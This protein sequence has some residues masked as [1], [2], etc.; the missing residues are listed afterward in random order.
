[1]D[2]N[3]D[4][5]SLR[6]QVSVDLD[7]DISAKL[8]ASFAPLV[9]FPA[10]QA[11]AVLTPGPD[12]LNF[13]GVNLQWNEQSIAGAGCYW[14]G[15]SPGLHLALSSRDLDLDA[16]SVLFPSGEADEFDLPLDV[17]LELRAE[18]AN[19]LGARARDVEVNVGI[20]RVCPDDIASG[21]RE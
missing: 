14:L 15:P 21:A 12:R 11:R 5:R 4:A 10:V 7:G 18:S 1:V 2:W 9:D 8:V 17:S 16:L 6:A 3:P 20:D 13:T 19:Y